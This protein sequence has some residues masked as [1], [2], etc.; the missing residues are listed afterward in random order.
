MKLDENVKKIF[1]LFLPVFF[2]NTIVQIN[3]M[4]DRSFASVLGA[5][6]VSA[7]NYASKL[8]EFICAVFIGSIATALFP[9]ISKLNQTE[10]S[11]IFKSYISKSLNAISII[12]VPILVGTISLSKPIVKI[13]FMRGAFD[14]AAVKLT[15]ES[16]SFYALGF[17]AIGFNMILCRVFYSL[18]DTKT[19]AINSAIA[20]A[21]NI[22]MNFLLIKPM[23]H[24]GLALSTSLS[25]IITTVLLLWSLRKSLGNIGLKTLAL[26]LMKVILSAVVMGVV[27]SGIYIKIS[28][29]FWLESR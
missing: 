9:E 26:E 25:G 2:S 23:A 22:I 13:L 4:F 14:E 3:K 19:P 27:V 28:T 6:T 1:Y 10:D 12:V 18:Q 16:L 20:M 8:Q 21:L 7:M 5:G 11:N 24:K 29:S 15:S 17:L